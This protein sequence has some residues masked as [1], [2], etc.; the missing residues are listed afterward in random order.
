[1][2]GGGV[3][4]VGAGEGDDDVVGVVLVVELVDEVVGGGEEQLAG[5]RVDDLL[6]VRVDHAGD[7]G[8]VRDPLGKD[9]HRGDGT[10]DHADGQV[11][12]GDD[13]DD[14]GDH[15]DRLA[16]RHPL[17]RLGL[18]RVPVERGHRHHDHDGDQGG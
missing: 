9:D 7:I 11:V 17:E 4:D 12:G 18:D 15:D 16:H 13:E 10:D 5:D 1:G 14:R 8:Q 3:P 6:A 2:D